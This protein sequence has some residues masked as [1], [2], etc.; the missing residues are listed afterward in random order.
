MLALDTPPAAPGGYHVSQVARHPFPTAFAEY[1]AV[2]VG[3][4]H[5]ALVGL[6]GSLVC[7]RH[8]QHPVQYPVLIV[9]SMPLQQ[10]RLLAAGLSIAIR[11]SAWLIASSKAL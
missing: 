11:C 10:A 8:E 6:E 5:A 1:G 3:G 4:P 2:E 7:R 9:Q